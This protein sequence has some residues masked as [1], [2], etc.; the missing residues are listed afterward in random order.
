MNIYF[1]FGVLTAV[2][3]KNNISW[4]ETPCSLVDVYRC[5]VGRCCL[6][7]QGGKINK[8]TTT[9]KKAPGRATEMSAKFYQTTR[10]H[11]SE[12]IILHE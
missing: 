12:D 8:N 2:C 10:R 4:D 6:H 9:K 3:M 5:F 1:C 7:L 11:I